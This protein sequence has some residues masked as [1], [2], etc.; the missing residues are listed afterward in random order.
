MP[1]HSTLG[2]E[3]GNKPLEYSRPYPEC[4]PS[5]RRL[6]AALLVTALAVA[7]LAG[8]VGGD[9]PV[10]TK[11]NAI[12]G[13]L[14]NLPGVVGS[15]TTFNEHTVIS[16][17]HSMIE[18]QVDPKATAGQVAAVITSFAKANT[19]TGLDLLSSELHLVTKGGPDKLELLYGPITDVQATTLGASWLDLRGRYASTDL[20][21]VVGSSTGYVV[22]LSVGLGQ[23]S[24]AGDLTALHDVQAD[25]AKLGDVGRYEQVDGRFAAS[26]GLP[27]DTTLGFVAGLDAVLAADGTDPALRGEYDAL[28]DSFS[29]TAEVADSTDAT[30]GLNAAAIRALAAIPAAGTGVTIAFHS[31]ADKHQIATFD[32][33]SCDS[34]AG[35]PVS[36]PSRQLLELWA[37]DGRALRDGSAVASCFG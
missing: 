10:G 2:R 31:V 37:H 18:L 26:G 14:A 33:R 25:F 17:P 28:T 11:T 21:M 24:I 6:A 36:D 12:L 29:L 32:D 15:S 23:S 4:M 9:G 35:L 16:E 34:Y 27:S 8:C 22:N 30:N 7:G 3:A 13:A 1:P 20:A 5:T 19:E